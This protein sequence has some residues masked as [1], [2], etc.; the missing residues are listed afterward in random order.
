MLRQFVIFTYN[1][2]Y[3]FIEEV[4]KDE[5]MMVKHLGS[6]FDGYYELYK[7]PTATI[8]KFMSELDQENLAKLE[9][10]ILNSPY[11]K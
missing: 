9:K 5:P 8:V 6:K 1:F 4:W 10:H 7:N 2:R 3:N 11:Y